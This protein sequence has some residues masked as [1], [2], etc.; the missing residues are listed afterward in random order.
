[1]SAPSIAFLGLGAMGA[2][3]AGRVASRFTVTTWTKSGR[4][5]E[6]VAHAPSAQACVQ[7]AN[8]VIAVLRDEGALDE[9]LRGD[10]GVLAAIRPGTL[11]IDMATSGRTSALSAARSLEARGCR[12]VDAPV[13]GTVGPAERGELVALVGAEPEDLERAR[14]VLTSMC[15]K[16]VHA[17][18][19]G[20]GQAL[21]VVLNGLGAH[22]FVAFA[23]M[24]ALGERAGLSREAIV[25][26]FTSGAFASPS[27][28]GKKRK[29]LERDYA[30]EFA[31]SLA[32]KDA[33]LTAALARETGL[34]LP[35]LEA[36]AKDIDEGVESGLGERDLFA[37]EEFFAKR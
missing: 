32:A 4:T 7:N 5:L 35:V 37:L 25:D 24:L 33:A 13:S 30:P 6:G 34:R 11:F 14:P 28:I 19:V 27:Y 22:H 8:I 3:M 29:V 21:K 17:G 9:V 2:P 31:L 18:P 12:F 20:Q 26:A 1:M 36:I 23:S 10:L 16:I 15:R